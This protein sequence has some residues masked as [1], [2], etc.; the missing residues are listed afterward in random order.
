MPRSYSD[1]NKATGTNLSQNIEVPA[2]TYSQVPPAHSPNL[3][4]TP[5]VTGTLQEVIARYRIIPST[6]SKQYI[7]GKNDVEICQILD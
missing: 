4:L 3:L 1:G 7:A 5:Q 6:R 2:P